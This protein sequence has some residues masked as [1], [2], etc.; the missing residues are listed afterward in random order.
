VQVNL[1]DTLK[2]GIVTTILFCL[3]FSLSCNHTPTPEKCELSN[4]FYQNLLIAF[5][6]R[7]YCLVKNGLQKIEEAGIENKRTCYL[8]AMVALNEQKP[9]EAITALKKALVF[10][11]DYGDARNTLGSIYMQ[12]KHLT[13]A[14][15]EFLSAANNAL[16]QTPEKAYHN[17]GKLYQLQNKHGEAQHCY[18]KAV[19]L[20]QDYFP[21]HYEL[22]QLYLKINKFEDAFQEIERS[23]TLSPEHPGVWLYLGKIEKARKN[24]EQARQA[25]K[26]TIKL[27]PLGFFGK[28]ANQ[29][30]NLLK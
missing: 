10:D 28:Q 1:I 15:T 18:S 20:N 4:E 23:R 12:Q 24:Q 11:P 8:K 19:A 29:E 14:E 6:A 7:D 5:T 9:E 16:Y 17:L 25:F 3:I 27:Q 22:S 26:Q 2:T 13:A 21:S 30:L